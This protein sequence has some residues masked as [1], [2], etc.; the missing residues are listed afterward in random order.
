MNGESPLTRKELLSC[1]ELGKAIT[2]EL[3]SQNLF[4][5]I[6]HKI[7]ELL[8]AENWSLLLLN[9]NTGELSFKLSVNL[10]LEILRDIRLAPGE[11][12]A[13]HVALQK[14][15]MIVKDVR[16]CSFFSDRIDRITGFTT[17]SIIC[18]PLLFGGRAL[19]VIE[20]VNP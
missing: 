6:L 9:E 3:D 18:V 16:K 7:S 14:K 13:G 10:D 19:G 17:K 8:P 11:G 2:A 12:I 5:T 4:E 20:V 15:P 1:M